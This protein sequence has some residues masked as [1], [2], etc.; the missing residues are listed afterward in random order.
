[1]NVNIDIEP[2][3]ENIFAEKLMLTSFFNC[4]LE[5]LR[6]LPGTSPLIYMYVRPGIE[7][8]AGDGD[9]F[10]QLMRIFMDDVAVLKCARLGFVRIAD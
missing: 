5:D 4:A 3:A 7:G 1:M 2:G 8:E 6:H 9:A 10:Q